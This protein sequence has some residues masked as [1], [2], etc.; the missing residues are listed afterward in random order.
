[1]HCRGSS[2]RTEGD[3]DSLWVVEGVAT[4]GARI[5]RFAAQAGYGVVEAPRMDARAQR[6]TGKSHPIDARR[7][8]TAVLAVDTAQLR[9]PRADE[10]MRAALRT[11]ITARE[12]MTDD[13]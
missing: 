10:G 2:P 7:I 1:M 5:A 13:R 4:Y 3:L 11:L 6:G 12:H 9:H 8:A